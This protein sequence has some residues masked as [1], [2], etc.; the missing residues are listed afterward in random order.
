MKEYQVYV[1]CGITHSDVPIFAWRVRQKGLPPEY[2]V[3]DDECGGIALKYPHKYFV[4]REMRGELA[5]G[6]KPVKDKF[7]KET[8]NKKKG[9][10]RWA[11]N[12]TPE[13]HWFNGKADYYQIG[14][15]INPKKVV[16]LNNLNGSVSN[17]TAKI[18]PFKAMRGKQIPKMRASN[19]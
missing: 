14:D 13:Y 17:A 12:V 1:M 15:K 10:F 8:Y 7:G 4:L 18:Y 19:A 11:K 16:Q 5:P 2:R 6:Y 9:S 3:L